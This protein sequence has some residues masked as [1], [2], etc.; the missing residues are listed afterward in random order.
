MS[1]LQQQQTLGYFVVA[2]GNGNGIKKHFWHS[3]RVNAYVLVYLL[4][5]FPPSWVID[6]SRNKN[7]DRIYP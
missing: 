5:V 1:K 6:E 2:K 7:K 3:R 4:S